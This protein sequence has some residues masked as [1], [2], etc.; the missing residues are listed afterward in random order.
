M[1]LALLIS[2]VLGIAQAGPGVFYGQAGKVARIQ[3]EIQ[4]PPE[5]ALQKRSVIT[6][7]SPFGKFSKNPSGTPWELEP[8]HYLQRAQPV[9][10][11]IKLPQNPGSFP[12]DIKPLDIKLD[13]KATLLVCHKT[14]GVCLKREYALAALLKMGSPANQEKT[15]PLVLRVKP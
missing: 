10:W 1:R 14:L 12:L 2:V 3:L 9:V 6:L 5:F 15:Q 13:I 8:V 7:I 4:L 11:D